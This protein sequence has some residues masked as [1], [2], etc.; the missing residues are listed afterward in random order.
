[1]LRMGKLRCC[2]GTLSTLKIGKILEPRTRGVCDLG[3]GT[4]LAAGTDDSGAGLT[5]APMLLKPVPRDKV[6]A[7]ELT[8]WQVSSNATWSCN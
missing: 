4:G 8:H 7:Y 6:A 5:S 1:M 2:P 3:F